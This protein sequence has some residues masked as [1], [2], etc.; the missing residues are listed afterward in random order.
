MHAGGIGIYMYIYIYIYIYMCMLVVLFATR[1][2][3][4][5]GLICGPCVSFLG[6]GGGFKAGIFCDR[7]PPSFR[8]CHSASF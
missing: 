5:F 8:G 1:I 6:E 2:F 3:G 7:G 4:I